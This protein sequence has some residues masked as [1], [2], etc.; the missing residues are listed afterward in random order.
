MPSER[1]MLMSAVAELDTMSSFRVP[2]SLDTSG[3][4]SF[5]ASRTAADVMAS[6]F[7]ETPDFID[8]AA[9]ISPAADHCL[10][11]MARRAR[12]ITKMRFGNTMLLYIP[13]YISNECTNDCT[14]CNFHA[15]RDVFRR[16]L[17]IDQIKAEAAVIAAEGFRHV[18]FL[19]GE[20]PHVV[21]ADFLNAVVSAVRPLFE[22]LSLE[23][24]P[25]ETREYASLAAAGVDGL[26]VYQETYNRIRYA[27]VHQQ[28]RKRDY[29][30]RIETPDRAGRAGLRR[31]NLGCLLG[32]YDM[33]EDMFALALHVQYLLKKYWQSQISVSFPRINPI[34]GYEVRHPVRDRELTRLICAFRV[35]FPDVGI[36]LSTREQ[37]KFRD[38][39][40]KF[41]VTQA[42]AGSVTRPGGYALYPEGDGQFLIGDQRSPQEVFDALIRAGFDPVW[43]DFDRGFTAG[44]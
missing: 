7:R 29:Q 17:S 40:F 18:L 36:A 13:L 11:A 5:L 15:G 30:W 25:L 16:T 8:F 39:A 33:Y 12:R 42:S 21:N 14:Y 27:E 22:S 10:E 34:S 28:G 32:L 2:E 1:Q 24:Y 44:S 43:K 26:T 9:M 23:V 20:A 19:T 4:R 3:L 41:G 6:L 35:M 31:I 37:P 38:H